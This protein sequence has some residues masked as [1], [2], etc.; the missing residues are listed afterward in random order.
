MGVSAEDL[1]ITSRAISEM[2]LRDLALEYA[3][4][5]SGGEFQKVQIARALVQEPAV[6]MFDEPTNNQLYPF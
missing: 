2:G 3:D 1:A 4:R 5:I 6:M